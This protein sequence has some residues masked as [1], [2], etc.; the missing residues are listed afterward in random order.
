MR[1]GPKRGA[2]F[3]KSGIWYIGRKKRYKNK[4]DWAFL[5]GLIASPATAIIG[6]FAK[7][8]FKKKIGK[9]KRVR[10][11]RKIRLWKKR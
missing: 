7:P 9:G 5:F 2:Q 3:V 1:R 4:K 11:V 8:V 10:R 6:E